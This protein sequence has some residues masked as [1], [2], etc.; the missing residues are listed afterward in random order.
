MW[1]TVEEEGDVKD[2]SHISGINSWMDGGFV[3]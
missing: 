3:G 1:G 2:D